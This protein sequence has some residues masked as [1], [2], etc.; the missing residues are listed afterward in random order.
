MSADAQ[1]AIRLRIDP[2]ARPVGNGEVQRLLPF[3]THRMVGPFIFVDHIGPDELAPGTGT[4]VDAHPHIGLS[5]VT[6]LFAGRMVHRDSTGAVQTIE[7]GAVN[8]M[9]AGAGV[10]HTER[11]DPDD[12]PT[13]RT[14]H[15]FQTWVALPDDAEDGPASFE[16][17]AA[18]DVP[19]ETFGASRIRVAVGSGWGIESPVVGS[20]PLVLADLALDDASP[21]PV[22][23]GHPEVAVVVL[24]G[25][26]RVND[27]ALVNGQMAVLRDDV[28]ST[29]RGSGRVIVLGGAPVGTRRIWWNFVSSDAERLE[30][31]KQDWD[32]QRFPL[33]PGDH[34]PWVPLPR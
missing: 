6:Y 13:T 31:A 27:E 11:S 2:R 12:R 8:W 25:S 19:E 17:L 33:V 24:D 20:S 10:T 7:P 22:D 5:T 28:A 15:G 21:V 23:T 30:Q 32:A 16:H 3:R 26:V 9:T 29:L 1:S 34:D 14:L 18:A 4:D